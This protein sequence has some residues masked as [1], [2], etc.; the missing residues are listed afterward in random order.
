MRLLG[1]VSEL[2]KRFERWFG[3]RQYL[4]RLAAS[5]IHHC[6]ERCWVLGNPPRYERVRTLC[7][8]CG[9]VTQ[10]GIRTQDPSKL[11]VWC[12]H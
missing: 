3:R 8:F 12:L 7:C 2:A 10:S 9:S 11:A 6:C 1:R 5:R 4:R